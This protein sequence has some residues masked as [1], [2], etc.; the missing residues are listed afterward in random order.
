[1]VKRS[2]LTSWVSRAVRLERLG[3][4]VATYGAA[5]FS[6]ARGFIVAALAVRYA[7]FGDY[8]MYALGGAVSQMAGTIAMFGAGTALVLEWPRIPP[9]QRRSIVWRLLVVTSGIA[10]VILGIWSYVTIGLGVMVETHRDAVLATIAAASAIAAIIGSVAAN[11]YRAERDVK[12]YALATPIR[13]IAEVAGLA[14]GVLA[15]DSIIIGASI[16]LLGQLV[17]S[18]AFFGASLRNIASSRARV[19]KGIQVG[20]LRE[21][22]AIGSSHIAQDLVNRGDRLVI[23]SVLGSTALG[24]YSAAYAVSSL[25]YALLPPM[26]SALLPHLRDVWANSRDLGMRQLEKASLIFGVAVA[27]LAVALVLLRDPIVA[28]IVGRENQL[29]VSQLVP[30]LIAG[31]LVY[32]VGRILNI[33]YILDRRSGTFAAAVVFGGAID[34]VLAYVLGVRFGVLGAVWATVIG[35]TSLTALAL[36]L[37]RPDERLRPLLVGSPMLLVSVLLVLTQ[38]PI[39]YGA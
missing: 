4:Y 16:G 13:L 30:T 14:A 26:T 9:G 3:D 21:S 7:G 1:M 10:V 15:F 29:P 17:V 12:R 24:I 33:R 11:V 23:A 19:E 37:L 6:K 22:S 31:T 27:V 39:K 2:L 34:L 35:Y 32:V 28:L 8:G 5:F 36:V 25:I 20:L 18:M 38:G